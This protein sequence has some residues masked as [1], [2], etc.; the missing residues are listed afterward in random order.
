MVTATVRDNFSVLK[1]AE[2]LMD[3]YKNGLIP[4]NY[5]DFELSLSGYATG[6]VD[7]IVVISRLKALL[8]YETQYWGQ[9]VEREKAIARLQAV[10]GDSESE[11]E[12]NKHE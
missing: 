10:I 2:K 11:R 5:Q 3:L 7:A 1:T 12:G 8:D 9:R 6:K 4:K